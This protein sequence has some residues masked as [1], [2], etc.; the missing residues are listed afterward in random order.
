MYR[1]F[2][3]NLQQNYQNPH[4]YM[5]YSILK[6]FVT[7]F[8]AACFGIA[9]TYAQEL[10]APKS[11]TQALFL[12]NEDTLVKGNETA[13]TDGVTIQF[14]NR[15]VSFEKGNSSYPDCIIVPTGTRITIK[16][17]TF[18]NIYSIKFTYD[19]N[20]VPEFTIISA[21]AQGSDS[22]IV[23]VPSSSVRNETGIKPNWLRDNFY[24]IRLSE[25][26]Y[27][28]TATHSLYVENISVMVDVTAKFSAEDGVKL[29]ADDKVP[30]QKMSNSVDYRYVIKAHD[31]DNNPINMDAETYSTV[32]EN[33]ISLAGRT[34]GKHDVWV[35]VITPP[36]NLNL[37]SDPQKLVV[38]YAAEKP[39][40]CTTEI[41]TEVEDSADAE[42]YDIAGRKVSSASKGLLIRKTANKAALLYR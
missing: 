39:N 20:D 11:S 31:E 37:T 26:V 30:F 13:I 5:K 19:G 24:A 28:Y 32:P 23:P 22:N 7:V 25:I 40:E 18:E 14:S 10:Q 35:D 1:I 9:I 4:N 8:T 16:A 2:L 17:E 33:G 38:D 12:P 21:K 36:D 6:K 34:N 3:L 15:N 41:I 27:E 29:Y 42:Y